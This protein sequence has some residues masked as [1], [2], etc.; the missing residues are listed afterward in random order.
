MRRRVLLV[1]STVLLLAIVAV[2]V[3][4]QFTARHEFDRAMQMRN[5]AEMD[6]AA[7]AV[8]RDIHARID[9]FQSV[10]AGVDGKVIA[11]N[12]PSLARAEFRFL[13][14]GLGV[15]ENR[16]GQMIAIELHGNAYP[17]TDARGRRVATAYFLPKPGPPTRALFAGGV[18][19]SMLLA[20][21]IAAIA[22][23]ALTAVMLR[24]LF[25]PVEALTGAARAIA[26]GERGVRVPA[27]AD[28][29]G[30]LAA[31]FNGMSEA[32]AR[33]EEARRRMVSD[34]AHELRTPLT[35][36]RCAIEAA[37][38]GLAPLDLTSMQ[39]EIGALS[40]LVDDLQQLSLS[41]AGQLRLDLADVPLAEA[42][43][44]AVEGVRAQAR[45]IAINVSADPT[46]R[47]RADRARLGQILRNLLANAIRYA[48][49][50][51]DVTANGDG[52]TVS[53]DGPGFPP[54]D[55]PRVF[56]RFYRA[57]ASR[58]RAGGGSGLG[59]AIT[60]E[61]VLLHGGTISASNR[62]DG[63]A[64]VRFRLPFI[65]S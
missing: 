14:D 12:P 9:N 46:L 7:A 61:L 44:A 5:A 60:R 27:G 49:K 32:L 1:V 41:D 65:S 33:N 3:T 24:R 53:D 59:L 42:I 63:G 2:A 56:D 4:S 15:R 62:A 20:T 25:A 36:I 38:D 55:L 6:A 10:V 13:H 18:A 43:R 29:V 31:A 39:E 11:T 35:N 34:V 8:Q 26:R 37:E 51:V 30:E 45:G 50:S 52:V 23:L 19:R 17:I 47:V 57:D 21:I 54:D 16:D 28:E 48:R 22:G 64:V 58:S 40:R